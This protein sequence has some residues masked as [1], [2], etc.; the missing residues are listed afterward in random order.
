MVVVVGR[1]AHLVAIPIDS[2]TDSP[3]TQNDPSLNR[4]SIS[5]QY[6]PR[7]PRLLPE[8]GHR[9]GSGV[10]NGCNSTRENLLSKTDVAMGSL[11]VR[12]DQVAVQCT[13]A[14]VHGGGKFISEEKFQVSFIRIEGDLES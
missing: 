8:V 7:S 9:N 11:L 14:Q 1:G 2:P 6:E 12:L 5:Y 3:K 13:A 4:P 10:R